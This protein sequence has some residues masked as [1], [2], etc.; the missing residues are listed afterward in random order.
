M[1]DSIS[2]RGIGQVETEILTELQFAWN[3]DEP[4]HDRPVDPPVSKLVCIGKLVSGYGGADTYMVKVAALLPKKFDDIPEVFAI[5]QL[6]KSHSKELIQT[7][8]PMNFSVP[9]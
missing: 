8:E 4:L 7:S 3:G 6:A 1:L 2:H 5:S 9:Q